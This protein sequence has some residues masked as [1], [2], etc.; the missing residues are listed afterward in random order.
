MLPEGGNFSKSPPSFEKFSFNTIGTYPSLL[1]RFDLP[2]RPLNLQHTQDA[3]QDEDEVMSNLEDSYVDEDISM[4]EDQDRISPTL[5]SKEPLWKRLGLTGPGRVSSLHPSE[6]DSLASPTSSTVLSVPTPDPV[7]RSAAGAV[8]P[9]S[10]ASDN[11]LQPS[12]TPARSEVDSSTGLATPIEP[13]FTDSIG[14]TVSPS[15]DSLFSSSNSKDGAAHREASLPPVR[16]GPIPAYSELN[17]SSSTLSLDSVTQL[18]LNLF[19]QSDPEV[20]K[21]LFM[22]LPVTPL[23]ILLTEEREAWAE[24]LDKKQGSTGVPVATATMDTLRDSTGLLTPLPSSG[25]ISF[26]DSSNSPDLA[27]KTQTFSTA[28]QLL[29]SSSRQIKGEDHHEIVSPVVRRLQEK[30]AAVTTTLASPPSLDS[31][32]PGSSGF[33]ASKTEAGITSVVVPLPATTSLGTPSDKH[34]I[35]SI[36]SIVM[37]APGSLAQ[38][39]KAESRR[40]LRAGLRRMSLESSI[41]ADED[42]LLY[43]TPDEP[44]LLEISA[45]VEESGTTA[46]DSHAQQTTVSATLSDP[47]QIETAA[48]ISPNYSLPTI[49]GAATPGA[50]SRLPLPNLPLRIP[51]PLPPRPTLS[52]GPDTASPNT[53]LADPTKRQGS[54]S[55]SGGSASERK[56]R[57]K[58]DTKST[59]SLAAQKAEL[60]PDAPATNAGQTRVKLER[61][62]P[63]P[64]PPV[65]LGAGLG[66]NS[67]VKRSFS[68]SLQMEEENKENLSCLTD[69]ARPLKK[70]KEEDVEMNEVSGETSV[71]DAVVANDTNVAKGQEAEGGK[72][73]SLRGNKDNL[74]I[75]LAQGKVDAFVKSLE[76]KRQAPD[77]EMPLL[78]TLAIQPLTEVGRPIVPAA[79]DSTMTPDIP[80]SPPPSSASPVFATGTAPPKAIRTAEPESLPGSLQGSR[81]P[82]PER[83]SDAPPPD[84]ERAQRVDGPL[85][86]GDKEY[87]HDGRR[88]H[89]SRPK[90]SR[91]PPP[92]G[93]HYIPSDS[94]YS[95]FQ[96]LPP[97]PRGRSPLRRSP[98]PVRR[99]ISPDRY[100]PSRYPRSRSRS[101]PY[102]SGWRGS[103]PP[104]RARARSPPPDSS[105]RRGDP[106]PEYRRY[107][108]DH[109]DDFDNHQQQYSPARRDR[110]YQR[111]ES[112]RYRS[113]SPPSPRVRRPQ[114][115]R[116]FEAAVSFE[117]RKPDDRTIYPR[118]G[119]VEPSPAR[120][121]DDRQEAPNDGARSGRRI[122]YRDDHCPHEERRRS[123]TRS[124]SLD[125]RH[126]TQQ[127]ESARN[128]S[129][130]SHQVLA[131][132]HDEDDAVN[133]ISNR[134]RPVE[135]PQP[136]ASGRRPRVSPIAI[137]GSRFSE[138]PASSA[139]AITGGQPRRSQDHIPHSTPTAQHGLP[140]TV[141]HDDAPTTPSMSVKES[142][143]PLSERLTLSLPT[144]SI[145]ITSHLP[146]QPD[147]SLRIGPKETAQKR[148]LS[149]SGP[150]TPSTTVKPF[151][152]RLGRVQN[153]KAASERQ[154]ATN[155]NGRPSILQKNPDLDDSSASGSLLDRMNSATGLPPRPPLSTTDA[156]H[157][158]IAKRISDPPRQARAAH[159]SVTTRKSLGDRISDLNEQESDYESHSPSANRP[160]SASQA[161]GGPS[162]PQPTRRRTNDP[163]QEQ[164]LPLSARIAGIDAQRQER[165]ESPQS[166]KPLGQRIKLV[167]EVPLSTS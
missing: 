148:P 167:S 125:Q 23:G 9:E 154:A 105:F 86:D 45:D 104:P 155:D 120:G 112:D 75:K 158:P 150:S 18:P 115:E 32:S 12:G 14:L 130:S 142:T 72:T 165:R 34:A 136:S 27:E 11:Q 71:T 118:V 21:S 91:R 56:K 98:S 55:G 145:D 153:R 58:E 28:P 10:I 46:I 59:V 4:N 141:A 84:S 146:A 22:K 5:A 137:H 74:L 152:E 64:G 99:P 39:D 47:E 79:P 26:Q 94:Q 88:L 163:H 107:Q 122:F 16:A 157:Q 121:Q 128:R 127:S 138:E 62:S 54:V 85:N 160:Q 40:E 17:S 87:L 164:P 93:D 149:A 25:A 78:P 31:I 52:P 110:E 15:N 108:L 113:L 134:G 83:S 119:F 41:D 109:E 42:M 36:P 19:T 156:S 90:K 76:F 44:E 131:T 140:P 3:P 61:Q 100:M 96:P 53:K 37:D 33:T 95:R 139:S 68:R 124:T 166:K 147:L 65:S 111:I 80:F 114:Y 6:P 57:R 126:D 73:A 77:V 117:G 144:P 101:P 106:S 2:P 51:H 49:S 35:S 66:L 123:L 63:A 67:G 38:G 162:R 129:P 103:S 116:P 135:I 50:Q 70:A 8:L 89:N 13:N 43:P 133:N 161:R 159:A 92:R 69:E 81:Q 30:S 29:S 102:Y 132:L 1:D 82:S 48:P 143:V 24:V 97:L 20:T 7:P 151:T 60:L